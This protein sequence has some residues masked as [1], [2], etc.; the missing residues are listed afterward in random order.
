MKSWARFVARVKAD[1]TRIAIAK[2]APVDSLSFVEADLLSDKG[3]DDAMKGCTLRH[4][5]RFSVRAGRAD[6]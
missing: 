4:A 5:R 2:V 1:A 6:G 3:W